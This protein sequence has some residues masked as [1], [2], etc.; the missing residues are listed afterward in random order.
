MRQLLLMRDFAGLVLAQVRQALTWA[1]VDM[2]LGLVELGRNPTTNSL[3]VMAGLMARRML[4]VFILIST[5]WRFGTPRMARTLAKLSPSKGT[6]RTKF[7]IQ[8]LCSKTPRCFSTLGTHLSSTPQLRG[9]RLS[10]RPLG[11]IWLRTQRD[12]VEWV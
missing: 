10:A 2:A 6:S 1:H 7:S 11:P 12:Q 9:T 3:T 5:P 4:S 8:L